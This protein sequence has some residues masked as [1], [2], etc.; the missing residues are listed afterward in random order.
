M[1]LT[2]AQ[3]AERIGASLEGD[4]SLVITGVAG[5]REAEPGQI[6]FLAN[7]RYAGQMA[8]T[9]ASAVIVPTNWDRP[10]SAPALLRVQNPDKAFA[11]VCQEFAP[12]PITPP[13]GVHPTAVVAADA[14][15]GKDVSIGPYVVIEPGVKIGDGTVIF[16]GCYIGHETTVGNQCRF[17]P[18]VTVRERTRIGNR[19]IIHNGAVIGSDGFGYTV[20]E[21]GEREKIPQL[22]IVEIGDDVEIGAN[23][24]VDR[25]RFGKTRIGKGVKIDN[26]VQIAHNVVIGDH[27]VIVALSGISGS[28]EV[29][30]HTILAGQSGVVGHVVIGKNCIVAARAGVTKDIPDGQFVSGFPAIPHDENMKIQAYTQR[31]PEFR[32][33]LAELEERVKALEQKLRSE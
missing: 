22:G 7:M 30:A 20:N 14:E 9:R 28:S 5:L 29:G 4:G 2:V 15:L 33:K 23:V 17:Y 31:L 10:C 8:T 1:A 16:A 21:R 27:A 19:V 11:I 6:S 24:T 13:P 32:K 3:L 26:L 12:P 25:A 18:H